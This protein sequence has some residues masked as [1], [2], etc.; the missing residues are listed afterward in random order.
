MPVIAHLSDTHLDMSAQRAR[1]FDAVLEQVAAL[2]HVDAVLISGDLTDHGTDDEYAQFFAALPT[3]T[4]TLVVPGNHDLAAPLSDAIRAAGRGGG[5][6]ATINVQG[7]TLVGLDSHIDGHD[8]GELAVSAIDFAME[9]IAA[10]AGPVILVLHH[11]PV[12]VGHHVMDRYGLGNPDALAALVRE[13]D[14]VVGVFTG[15]VHSA[16]ATTFAGVPLIGAPGIV[17]TMRLGSKTDPIADTSAMPGLA[18]HTIEG[19]RIRT[20]FHYLSPTDL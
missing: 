16:L 12:P 6:N 13:H 17:S 19:T 20:V 10:A 7:L 1:R 15:H 18:L 4:P 3:A 9:S 11:P 5:L 14:Q 2:P 8:E